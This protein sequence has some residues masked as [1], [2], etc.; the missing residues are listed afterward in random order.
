MVD[1]KTRLAIQNCASA[2]ESFQNI[3]GTIM[4]GSYFG[5][6]VLFLHLTILS[7]FVHA[8][9][10]GSILGTVADASGASIS[11]ASVTITET[12][13]NTQ[14]VLTTDSAGRY[15]ANVL[16][17]GNYAIKVA[18]PGFQ[19]VQ[20]SGIVLEAQGSP[21]INFT[22]SPSTVNE[23]VIVEA[24]P[25]AVDT[26]NASLSQVVHSE[27][28]AD[29]PL[30]GRNFVELATLAPGVSTGDQP[31]DFFSGG[32]SSGSETS[33][34]GSFS[35]SFGGS[36]ENRTDFLYDGVDDGELTSGA[37]GVVPSIDALQEF[38]VLTSNYSIEYGT[39]AGPT[40]LLISK[41]GSNQ[42]HGTLFDFLRNTDLNASSYF[43]PV[44][45]E[46]IRNQYGGSIG[47]PI[48][49][50][51]TFFFFDYEGTRSVQGIPSLTQVPT[52]LEREGIF[53]ESFPG[54]PEVP[55]YDPNT[56]VT[57]PVTG[58]MTRTQFPGNIIPPGRISSIAQ[59][60]LSYFPLPNVP[61]VLSA[62]YVNVPR[63]T[64]DEDEFDIRLDH[65]FS[66]T[67]R[68]F[69]RF[70]R[71]QASVYVPSGLP[72]F[73]SQPGGYA[74]NQTLADRGRNIAISETH[75][76]AS[77]KINQFTA[78]YNR[79][80]DHILSY[81]DGT[82]WSDQLGIPNAN[83]GTYFSSG[84]LN[85]QFNEG[86]WGL[87]DRGFSP[88]QD[89][90]NVFHYSDDF[91]WVHG[92]HSF[93]IGMGVRFFQLNELGDSFPMGEMSFDNLFTAGFLNGS[94]NSA[95]GNP[96][97]SFLLGIPAGGEHDNEFEGSISG[98]RWKEFR[99]YFQDSWRM[100]PNLTVQLGLAWNYTTPTVEAQNRYSNFD[101]ATG[102]LLIAGVNSSKTA[103]LS[104]YYFGFEPRIG[105]S[106]SPFSRKNSIRAGYAI[107][108]DAGWNLGAEGLDLN[109]PFYST[110][111]FQTDDVTPT[112]TLSQGFP[113]PV[114]PTLSTLSGN[115]YSQNTNF[116]LGLIQ[117]FNLNVQRE[118]PSNIVLTVG[119]VGSRASHLQTAEWNLNT[120][121]PNPQIDPTNLR[122]YPQFYDIIGVL[123]RGLA[124]Y[125]SLQVKAEKAYK[126]G[127]YFLVSYAYEKGFDNG[128]NDDLGSMAG[129]GYYPLVL[130]GYTDKGLSVIDQTNNLSASVLYQLP[131]GKGAHFGSSARGFTQALIGNWQT[132]VIAHIGSGFPMGLYTG[133]NNSGT[134]L[135]YLGNR[136]DQVCSGKLSHSSVQEFFNTS[137]FI[138]PPAGVLGGAS[139]T[140]LF[141]PD[142]VNFDAS[143]FKTFKVYESARL[144]F[145][146]EVFN[147][148]NHPQFAFP[149]TGT[150]SPGFGEITQIVN[151]PRLI[152]FA[153]KFIF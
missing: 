88:I 106:Y 133:V 62:N 58:D 55:I 119:Y 114:Q 103:G 29:L 125:D 123:D 23:N 42:F 144:E 93:S 102:N 138:D 31:Y 150:D 22:L 128:L 81:G 33:I 98:R 61:G 147:V 148:F 63:E 34:R 95:T 66:A 131:F 141:G 127:L 90:T 113:V 115:V 89:G 134:E 20:K 12:R 151:N 75:I 101:F 79:I 38:N 153:L 1:K 73:G 85:T 91:E 139:R 44:N 54:A 45:P 80:F 28:V 3:E 11:G 111:A 99:P 41:S 152:Q 5:R 100:R 48:R 142:F 69:A 126:N 76:F 53:T 47:G 108:H 140:P 65:T 137:C 121:P 145:R 97:A 51:K 112:T 13:T 104:S 17:V 83:L 143:L 71:D 82:N 116:R 56:T 18:A 107:L 94:L 84:F 8:Q 40:V 118:L 27:Q 52:A 15:L 39:R 50:D 4:K 21:E 46:Y 10:T 96:I 70:T 149:G 9:S 92:A 68:A 16:Q 130:P 30:N 129:V 124:R 72:G 77:N 7:C 43:S 146:T 2:F 122:P 60:M 49:K 110:Y 86:Y 105:V 37:L 14:R 35:L 36:R 19:T 24:N 117:Q 25:V 87:G 6:T 64:Y 32:A 135:G 78:G 67:D 120:A 59:K 109:P 74:S 57:D 136:P 26:A 132:N